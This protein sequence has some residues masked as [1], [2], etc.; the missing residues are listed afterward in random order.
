MFAYQHAV[1]AMKNQSP[2][3]MRE[4]LCHN[5]DSGGIRS[6]TMIARTSAAR[7]S[8]GMVGS[9]PE[10]SS[11]VNYGGGPRSPGHCLIS[12]SAP[13]FVEVATLARSIVG[14][15]FP[16]YHRLARPGAFGQLLRRH[17]VGDIVFVDVV[18]I[19][20]HDPTCADGLKRRK[21][22]YLSLFRRNSFKT[23]G[24][25]VVKG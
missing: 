18:T 6:P 14:F 9:S 24:H 4:W 17:I 11:P 10:G 7:P 13:R 20:Q 25:E 15:S 12:R 23:M 1:D 19:G 8:T 3:L 16:W 2:A 22:C 21:S 5:R